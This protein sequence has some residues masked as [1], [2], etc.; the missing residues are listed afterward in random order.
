MIAEVMP[1]LQAMQWFQSTQ[2]KALRETLHKPII[3]VSVISDNQT[4][5]RQGNKEIQAG[6]LSPFWSAWR[7][8]MS[9]GYRDRFYHL[10]RQTHPVNALC[11]YISGQSR[12][13][14]QAL[15]LEKMLPGDEPFSL[16]SICPDL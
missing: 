7:N 15:T 13:S 4:V 12:L 9:E 1:Y 8:L 10:G 5:V 6:K 2:A 14:I 11:D 16:Y 3:E